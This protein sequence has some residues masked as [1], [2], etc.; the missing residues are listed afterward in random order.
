MP[1]VPPSRVRGRGLSVAS[2]RPRVSRIN[3]IRAHERVL[4]VFPRVDR[5]YTGR[6]TGATPRVS[7]AA[8]RL[9]R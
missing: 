6:G 9:N 5:V 7:E 4:P 1:G 2:A 3:A 8:D